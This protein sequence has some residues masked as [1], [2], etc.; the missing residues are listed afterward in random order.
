MSLHIEAVQEVKVLDELGSEDLS[1]GCQLIKQLV[2]DPG[3]V[4]VVS[5][6]SISASS[7]AGSMPQDLSND[8]SCTKLPN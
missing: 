7:D 5:G 6:P 1:L 3:F 2:W 8:Q 4:H